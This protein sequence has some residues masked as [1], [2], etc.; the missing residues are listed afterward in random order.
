[1]NLSFCHENFRRRIAEIAAE[2]GTTSD[3]VYKL[4]R[5]YTDRC[6]D[7]SCLLDEFVRWYAADLEALKQ[8]TP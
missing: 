7:Q 3:E 4:W 1:M 6:R 5:D 8:K 2:Y